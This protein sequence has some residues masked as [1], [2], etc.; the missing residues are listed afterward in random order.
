MKHNRKFLLIGAIF[1]C[2]PLIS[3]ID[4][5][6][7]FIGYLFIMK[8]LYRMADLSGYIEDARRLCGRLALAA[9]ARPVS[10]F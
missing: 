2:D 1:L 6:P 5:L 9:L 3:V 8:G 7:D 10:C 4:L